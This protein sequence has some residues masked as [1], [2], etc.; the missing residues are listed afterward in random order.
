MKTLA[1][2]FS[3]LMCFTGLSAQTLDSLK[4]V[5]VVTEVRD[6]MALV[7]NND[8]NIINKVFYERDILDS[9]NTVNDSLIRKLT[10]VNIA[11]QSIIYNMQEIIKTDS[12]IVSQ[13][14]NTIDYKNQVIQDTENEL[15]KQKKWNKIWQST[16]G[17]LAIISLILII[18]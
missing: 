3:F 11:Q 10:L 6:S 15:D 1:I 12:L 17:V 2:I 18:L 7:N 9:L 13:Y 8:I 4:H 5:V 14:K 16:S